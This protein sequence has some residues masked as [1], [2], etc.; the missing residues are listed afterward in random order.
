[1]RNSIAVDYN[2]CTSVLS[3]LGKIESPTPRSRDGD[4]SRPITAF[5]GF[6][7][8]GGRRS[9]WSTHFT[10]S[11]STSAFLWPEKLVSGR[12]SRVCGPSATLKV[13][14]KPSFWTP[15]SLHPVLS[16]AS[17]SDMLWS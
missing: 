3:P 14:L 17:V 10:V 4:S 6:G 11:I 7:G 8:G 5:Y 16:R 2:D 15:R 12:T 13:Q 9:Q 1:M